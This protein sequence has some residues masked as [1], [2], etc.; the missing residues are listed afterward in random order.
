MIE[1]FI[2]RKS[3]KAWAMKPSARAGNTNKKGTQGR[4]SEAQIKAKAVKAK[5]DDGDKKK[6]K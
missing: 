4:S 3:K 5:A 1:N 6:K 2:G